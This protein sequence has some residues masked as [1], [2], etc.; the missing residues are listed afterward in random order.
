VLNDHRFYPCDE[1]QTAPDTLSLCLALFSPLFA[2]EKKGKSLVFDL[3]EGAEFGDKA[4]GQ[5]E[6]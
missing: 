3:P 1:I 5:M 4:N 6:F 2:V